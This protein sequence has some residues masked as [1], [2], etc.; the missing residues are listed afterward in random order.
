MWFT[1]GFRFAVGVGIAVVAIGIGA[2]FVASPRIERL[3]LAGLTVVLIGSIAITGYGAARLLGALAAD[4]SGP[5]DPADPAALAAADTKLDESS[6]T[7]GFHLVLLE[8]ELNAVLQDSLRDAE[9]PFRSITID[10]V[11]DV[12][13]PGRIDFRGRLKSGDM[14][15]EGLLGAEVTGGK[16]ELEILELDVGM[17]RLPGVARSAIED[18][19]S[20]VADLEGAVA[21]EG[22]D[23]QEIV[24]GDDRIVVTGVNR[25]AAP[26]DAD[27]I[28]LALGEAANPE[29]PAVTI[30]EQYGPGRVG[31]SRAEGETYYLALGDSLAAS[32]GVPTG[33]LGYVSRFH[34]VLEER[35]GVEYGMRNFGISGETSG[36]LLA[37]G[38][39]DD[40]IAFAE[41]RIV[42]YVTIDI[43]ANDLLGHLGSGVCS[44]DIDDPACEER[45]EA[46]LAAYARNIE[47]LFDGLEAAFLDSTIVFL[48]AYNPFSFG[49]GDA[50][51]FEVAS[52]EAIAR[53][54][55]IATVAALARGFLVAD[56]AGPMR[57]TVTQTTHMDESPP[58]IHPNKLGYDVLTG[59][60]VG[61]LTDEA[62]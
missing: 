50:V 56:G 40:A 47:V 60:L 12:G 3:V 20:D 29:L 44:E 9:H 31:G 25:N 32:I 57:G 55:D 7:A 59:A 16:V 13:N 46:S 19:I 34:S 37:G 23:L 53:L 42:D 33:E 22:A 39:L 49:F 41:D 18:M 61:A 27:Q 43:G 62:S 30:T 2:A 51:R 36:S 10:I 17:F 14:R 45:I 4:R 24:I 6:D 58:D 48:T 15:V 11:N 38:Q 28:L 1:V 54:N 21:S 52:D 26:I 5:V 35:D 8:T